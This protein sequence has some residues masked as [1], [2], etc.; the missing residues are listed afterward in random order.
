MTKPMIPPKDVD[1]FKT[2][3]HTLKA[4]G[5]P[6]LPPRPL[7]SLWPNRPKEPHLCRIAVSRDGTLFVFWCEKVEGVTQVPYDWGHR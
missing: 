4:H 1:V 6:D 7:E 3:E 5:N 2:F